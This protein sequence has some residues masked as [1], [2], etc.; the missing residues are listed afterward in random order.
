MCWME[1]QK[2]SRDTETPGAV[3]YIANTIIVLSN[4]MRA[5]ERFSVDRCF[6]LVQVHL[7][8]KDLN[9]AFPITSPPGRNSERKFESKDYQKEIVMHYTSPSPLSRVIYF[10]N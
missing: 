9:L 6:S 5:L 2:C 4:M 10:C 7:D 8:E 1:E 3:L